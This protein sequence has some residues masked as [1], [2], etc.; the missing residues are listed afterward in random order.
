MTCWSLES[1]ACR[2]ICVGDDV[3]SKPFVFVGRQMDPTCLLELI[4]R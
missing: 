3:R 4:Y 1:V 2:G